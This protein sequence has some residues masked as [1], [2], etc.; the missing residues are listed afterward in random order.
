MIINSLEQQSD[1]FENPIFKYVAAL[2]LHG[3]SPSGR[4]D[5]PTL[6]TL[7]VLASLW[8]VD[9]HVIES[10]E[11][12]P[13]E[14]RLDYASEKLGSVLKQIHS[15]IEAEVLPQYVRFVG[16]SDKPIQN[17]NNSNI[18]VAS[19]S[20]PERTPAYLILRNEEDF[21][22]YSEKRNVIE[23]VFVKSTRLSFSSSDEDEGWGAEY[24]I[25]FL[26]F[27]SCSVFIYSYVP[28]D[29][30]KYWFA[31]IYSASLLFGHDYKVR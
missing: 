24:H 16:V 11:D 6:A 4:L 18:G 31:F 17:A 7:Q 3:F 30:H 28:F 15:M 10:S 21:A 27:V 23:A 12:E 5:F 22:V 26:N 20:T 19:D 25:N 2:F 13:A 14:F 8:I 29:V 9:F 1:F